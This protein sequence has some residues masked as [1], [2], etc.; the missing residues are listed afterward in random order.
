MKKTLYLL[1][2]TFILILNSVLPISAV[3]TTDLGMNQT[4]EVISEEDGIY[5]LITPGYLVEANPELLGMSKETYEV[6]LETQ[7][8]GKSKSVGGT[9]WAI[10]TVATFGCYVIDAINDFD[11]CQW[12]I[13]TVWNGLKVPPTGFALGKYKIYNKFIPGKVPGCVPINS[14]PCN[15]GRWETTYVKI[16]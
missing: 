15:S 10:I 14:G 4:F 12:F 16:T 3:N 6:E 9:V 7:L 2:L 13:R 5:K 11:P 8:L 1:M